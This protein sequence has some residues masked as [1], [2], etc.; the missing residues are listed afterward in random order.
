MLEE[1]QRRIAEFIASFRV[2]PGAKVKLAKD[3]DPSHKATFIKKKD[4]VKF[5]QEGVELLAEY[6]SRLAA[7]DTW[8]CSSASRRLTLPG[9]TARS[10]TS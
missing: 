4:G 1:R 3:F 6:Q 7:Q 9:R 10:C 5:L 8:A 2:K